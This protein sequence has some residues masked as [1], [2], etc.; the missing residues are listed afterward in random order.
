[1][2]A[3]SGHLMMSTTSTVA[4]TQSQRWYMLRL[5]P[6]ID[7]RITICGTFFGPCLL[8]RR[9][10]MTPQFQYILVA[11]LMGNF[12][13]FY[14]HFVDRLCGH[15]LYFMPIRY[16]LWQFGICCGNSVYVVA[17]RYMLWQFGICCGNTLHYSHFQKSG[18]PAALYEM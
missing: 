18:N 8:L 17:I 6:R 4:F 1:M 13:I 15:L 2:R 11:I 7:E 9:K 16:M 5:A 10:M 12:D 3:A 14:D